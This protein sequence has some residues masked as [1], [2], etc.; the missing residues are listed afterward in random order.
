MFILSLS[1]RIGNSDFDFQSWNSV[2]AILFCSSLIS[3]ILLIISESSS[4]CALTDDLLSSWSF[5]NDEIKKKSINEKLFF[6]KLK[7]GKEAKFLISSNLVSSFEKRL[8][9]FFSEYFCFSWSLLQNKTLHGANKFFS[10][11]L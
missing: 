8:L 10:S 1:A 7:I 5:S 6:W 3:S 4:I 11:I 2:M 9:T